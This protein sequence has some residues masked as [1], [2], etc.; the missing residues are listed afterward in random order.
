MINHV[1]F[2]KITAVASPVGPVTSRSQTWPGLQPLMWISCCGVGLKSSEKVP[3]HPL[4]RVPLCS[5]DHIFV[6][7]GRSCSL[8]SDASQCQ[9][10]PHWWQ[11]HH[12]SFHF[13]FSNYL[14]QLEWKIPENKA[15]LS[16]VPLGAFCDCSSAGDGDTRDAPYMFVQRCCNG[17][18]VIL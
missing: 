1:H 6:W 11:C 14:S 15:F 13:S 4:N 3:G 9:W 2:A 8:W 10:P 17:S 12:C 18:P 7:P 5:N 16:L